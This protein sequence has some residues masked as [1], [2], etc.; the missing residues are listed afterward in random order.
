MVS[1]RFFVGTWNMSGFLHDQRPVRTLRDTILQLRRAYC[2]S[3]GFEVRFNQR[4][5]LVII[6]VR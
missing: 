3:I 2:G 6:P 5:T 4:V 1:Y